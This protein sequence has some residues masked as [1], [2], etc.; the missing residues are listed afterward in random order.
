MRSPFYKLFAL[1]I[2]A[3]LLPAGCAHRK[4]AATSTA[5]ASPSQKKTAKKAAETDLG[6]DKSG[7][8]RV[9]AFARFAAGVSYEL[10][11]ESAKALEEFYQAALADPTNEVVVGDVARRL[12]QAK[13]WEKA[14]TLLEKVTG[15]GKATANVWT[16]LGQ[17]YA[18]TDKFEQAVKANRM[19]IELTPQFTPAYHNLVQLYLDHRLPGKAL[20]MIDEA[21]ESATGATFLMDLAEL[22]VRYLR[23]QKDETEAVKPKILRNLNRAAELKPTNPAILQRLGDSFWAQNE[24]TK[25]TELYLDILKRFPDHT[26]T[27]EKLVN[28]YLRSGKHEEATKQLESIIKDNPTSFPQAYYVLAILAREQKKFDIAADHLQK[29]LILKPDFEP[30]YYELAGL[31]IGNAKAE[32][33][34]ETIG[35]AR[36]KFSHKFEQDFYTGL[37]YNQLKDYAKAA[38]HLVAAEVYAN[39]GDTERL[40]PWFYF[41]LGAV[42]ERNKDYEQ[43]EE[44]FEKCLDKAP[45][46]AE[47]L[48]YLGYMWAERGVKLEES[49][50]LIERALKIEPENA[51]FLD[52]MAWVLFKLNQPKEA[53][54]YIQKAV[55]HLEEPDATIYDHLGDIHAQMKNLTAA[56][57]AWKKSLELE[58]SDEVRKKLEAHGPAKAP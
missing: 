8:Q 20:S 28:I 21:S 12:I 50:E 34:L 53:L 5:E 38:K 31:L 3:G 22:Y 26:A 18:Q 41:Q 44:Y 45:D 48:N 2:V 49:K 1:L 11:E 16:L 54:E 15:Q 55:K 10:R 58:A 40:T 24:L 29:L 17:A 23:T 4:G 32:Q 36:A 46:F 42:H 57:E 30:A 52:S 51:A 43:A 33:A 14:V 13:E 25:A 7:E 35:K 19:A 47:A 6:L 27:R 56:R 9:E 39:A 37:A